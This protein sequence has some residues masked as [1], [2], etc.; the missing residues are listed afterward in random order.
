MDIVPGISIVNLNEISYAD[1]RMLIQNIE[2]KRQ[3]K[4]KLEERSNY[5]LVRR[6][7]LRLSKRE[8]KQASNY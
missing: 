3:K 7:D 6:K 5:Q 4:N 8:R 1:D 2:R